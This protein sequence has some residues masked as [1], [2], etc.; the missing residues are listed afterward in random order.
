MILADSWS[1]NT[2]A[3]VAVAFLFAGL[4]IA[5][6]QLFATLRARMGVAR[7]A[8]YRELAHEVADSQRRTAEALE[9]TVAELRDLRQRTGELER[10]L[11][12]V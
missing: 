4:T 11:K 10:V 5:I 3:I 2:I 1:E 8:A 12:E 9:T 7:E 6:W